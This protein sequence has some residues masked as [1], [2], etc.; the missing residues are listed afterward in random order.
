MGGGESTRGC[1]TVPESP[2]SSRT[3]PRTVLPAP[4][5]QDCAWVMPASGR[6]RV[7][8]FSLCCFSFPILSLLLLGVTPHTHPLA[9][10]HLRI[11]PGSPTAAGIL[12]LSELQALLPGRSASRGR[13]PLPE[14]PP[15]FLLPVRPLGLPHSGRVTSE[16]VVTVSP[17]I[18]SDVPGTVLEAHPST[19]LIQGP[20]PPGP[21][22][23]Q[24][25]EGGPFS[26][27][28]SR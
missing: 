5:P 23:T 25:T 13:T 26:P 3:V 7:W 27:R 17:F 11:C 16:G 2:S 22:P 10:L 14:V 8:S 15:C 19:H 12:P 28:A 4:G 1:P 20:Q 9:R 6:P 24:K 21:F 18:E